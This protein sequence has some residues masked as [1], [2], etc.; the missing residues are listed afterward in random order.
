MNLE[1]V[2]HSGKII[3]MSCNSYINSNYKVKV[4]AE[5]IY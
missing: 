2:A 4:L 3:Y 1:V 5:G